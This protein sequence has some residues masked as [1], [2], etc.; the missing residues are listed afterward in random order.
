MF[1]KVGNECLRTKCMKGCTEEK[2]S[3]SMKEE[4]G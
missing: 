4:K 3:T 2:F 1:E